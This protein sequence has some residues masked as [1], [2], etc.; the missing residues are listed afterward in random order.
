MKNCIKYA[1]NQEQNFLSVLE[2]HTGKDTPEYATGRVI[3]AKVVAHGNVPYLVTSWS[4]MTNY[5]SEAKKIEGTEIPEGHSFKQLNTEL[6]AK[7]LKEMGL[8]YD[9]ISFIANSHDDEVHEMVDNGELGECETEDFEEFRGQ[10]N[11]SL[12]AVKDLCD[13]YGYDFSPIFTKRMNLAWQDNPFI[14][15]H[16]RNEGDKDLIQECYEKYKT[17]R[18]NVYNPETGDGDYDPFFHVYIGYAGVGNIEFFDARQV[19]VTD[20]DL[21]DALLEIAK[22]DAE[23]L[24]RAQELAKKRRLESLE[25]K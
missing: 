11:K 3:W 1:E 5:Y 2:K 6:I 10:Y 12:T 23:L 9:R 16:H 24:A 25:A 14:D 20:H 22:G 15:V 17:L 19:Q 21:K 8:V 18:G 4:A 13:E 7:A